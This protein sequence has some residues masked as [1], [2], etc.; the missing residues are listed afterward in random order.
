MNGTDKRT[1][2]FLGT[3]RPSHFFYQFYY[4]FTIDLLLKES[5]LILAIE[6]F[7]NNPK[8]TFRYV[9]TIYNI[10]PIILFARRDGRPVRR[11]IPANSRK[12]TDLEEKT[13]I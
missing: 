9:V 13:I 1:V 4:Q 10:L 8:L 6:A 2:Y 7:K 11:D 12:L 3:I 5:R